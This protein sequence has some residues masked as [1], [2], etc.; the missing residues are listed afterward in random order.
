M[1]KNPI[2]GAL[3]PF[4]FGNIKDQIPELKQFD[5]IIDHTQFFPLLDSSDMDQESWKRLA[6]IIEA[7]Y[8]TYDGF[9]ILHGTD[10]MAYTASAISFMA[11]NLA[12]PIIFTGSQLPISTMRT[13][14]KENLITALEIAC[15]Y[16]NN[17][18]IVPEVAIYFQ[19]NLYRGNRSTKYNAENFNAFRS[20]NYPTLAEVGIH[21]K[22][23]KSYIQKPQADTT[24]S[25]CKE[26][27]NNIAL[28]KLFPGIN[29]SY[30]ESIINTPDLKAIVL[31]S[32][33]SGN[34]PTSRWFLDLIAE[35]ITKEII[36]LNV[37]QC[38]A[39]SVNMNRYEAGKHLYELGVHS[40]YDI[41][42]ESLK[43]RT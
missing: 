16:D 18:A 8:H 19:N 15:A 17:Q 4:D 25:M 40:G 31:E 33:G 13:D 11:E 37:T 26:M 22:Y 2:T 21:I 5:F 12:K 29:Q 41:T 32:F 1:V 30:I 24:F 7:H 3:A 10:T 35:A 39:G 38:I 6:A 28:I 9:V 36:I 20:D 27:D 23:N 14:A 42:S 43:F 34:A